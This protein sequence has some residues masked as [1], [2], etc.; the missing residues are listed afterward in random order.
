M[1]NVNNLVWDYINNKIEVQ[2]MLLEGLI[3][4]SALARKIA[5]EHNLKQNMDAIIS[6][7]RRY[8]C[9]VEKRKYVKFHD[10]LKKAKIST[11]TKL[12]SLLIKRNDQTEAKVASIY[13]KIVL[14]RESTLRIFEVTN[15]IKIII[16]D[17]F[18]E[19]IKKLFSETE[20][21]KI[22]FRSFYLQT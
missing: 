18:F 2:K 1:T 6:A 22:D 13:S 7:I 12:A 14:K 8:D 9:K 17:D 19:N 15:Y 5:K 4:S 20:I 3:N 16:D 21:E 11:K 10:L